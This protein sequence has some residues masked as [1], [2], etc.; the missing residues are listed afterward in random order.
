MPRT[1]TVQVPDIINALQHF[2]VIWVSL[3]YNIFRGPDGLYWSHLFIIYTE[4]RH[5]G[6]FSYLC[7]HALNLLANLEIKNLLGRPWL[8]SLHGPCRVPSTTTRSYIHYITDHFTEKD[9][10]FVFWP[11]VKNKQ[12][13]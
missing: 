1:G 8:C 9:S 3:C 5:Q 4:S 2:S 10:L 6:F 12:S 11:D 7:R 13:C